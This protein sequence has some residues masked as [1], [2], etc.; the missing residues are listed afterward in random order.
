M[1]GQTLTQTFN[2]MLK[3]NGISH[4]VYPE[5]PAKDYNE[6]IEHIT[7]KEVEYYADDFKAKFDRLWADFK[8]DIQ[9]NT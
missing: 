5:N 3:P 7:R 9:K 2:T 4:T 1:T 6:W 8:R